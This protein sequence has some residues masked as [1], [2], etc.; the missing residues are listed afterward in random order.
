MHGGLNHDTHKGLQTSISCICWQVSEERC[1]GEWGC[2]GGDRGDEALGGCDSLTWG[3]HVVPETLDI[4][5]LY[6]GLSYCTQIIL[7]ISVWL[8]SLMP[9]TAEM[10][11]ER[12]QILKLWKEAASIRKMLHAVLLYSVHVTNTRVGKEYLKNIRQPDIG[13]R[14]VI[15]AALHS[16]LKVCKSRLSACW[17]QLSTNVYL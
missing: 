1:F 16:Y 3:A 12:N 2:G 9:D 10:L 7:M 17:L 15:T 4:T 6:S 11:M 8:S 5:Q 13:C 14:P